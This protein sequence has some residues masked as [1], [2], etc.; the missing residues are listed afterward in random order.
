[1]QSSVEREAVVSHRV[2]P[3]IRPEMAQA[4]LRKAETVDI[5]ACLDHARR[6]AGWNLDELAHALGKDARQVRRWIDGRERVQMDAV[7]AVPELRAPF[8]IALAE[9]S[10]LDVV[11]TISVRS[12]WTGEERRRA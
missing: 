2:I 8:V 10:G 5:G 9:R 3:D 11:T 6:V 4:G 7:F 1:M 12:R